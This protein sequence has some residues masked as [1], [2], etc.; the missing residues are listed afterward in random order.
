M[1]DDTE[2]PDVPLNAEL[3]DVP[4]GME[5]RVTKKR[6]KILTTYEISNFV[7]A[8]NKFI[9]MPGN[10][11]LYQE[12]FMNAIMFALQKPVRQRV[13]GVKW[14]QMDLFKDFFSDEVRTIEDAIKRIPF[15]KGGFVY[16]DIHLSEI[17]PPNRY[18]DVK[19]AIK[20]FV[21]VPIRLPPEDKGKKYEVVR[22]F[23]NVKL[24][25]KADYSSVITIE[26]ALPVA[27]ALTNIQIDERKKIPIH[28]TRYGYEVAQ[29]VENKYT[30]RIYKKISSYKKKGGF[31]MEIEEFREWL[32]LG[33]MYPGF[34]DTKRRILGP[35]ADELREKADCWFEYSV[36]RKRNKVI[37]IIF[38][39]ISPETESLKQQEINVFGSF[40]F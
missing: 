12:R 29:Q 16:I 38:K 30:P 20:E 15:E 2:L 27:V 35:A 32:G 6:K 33:D 23:F 11:T 13:D 26:L 39:V 7:V 17:A 28:Y 14:E 5:K 3:L 21:S 19:K 10:F 37:R 4:P 25:T 36:I 22:S 9:E 40:F 31:T 24:P 34:N 8:P 1:K 18:G